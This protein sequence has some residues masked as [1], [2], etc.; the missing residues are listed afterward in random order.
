MVEP[1]VEGNHEY[2][3]PKGKKKIEEFKE[4]VSQAKASHSTLRRA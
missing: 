1:G 2:Y 3:Y 4:K